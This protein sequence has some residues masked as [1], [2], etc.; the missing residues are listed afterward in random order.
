MLSFMRDQGGESLPAEQGAGASQREDA[1]PASRESQEFLTVAANSKNLRRSTILVA[2]LV[3]IGLAGLG[4]M[5]RQ[6][7]PQAALGEPALEE[8]NKIEVAISRL[9][10]V[11]SEMVSRMDEIVSKFY[12]F[13]DVFQVGVGELAKNP[14]E[15]GMFMGVIKDEGPT[16]QDA[17]AQA[18]L[19][20]RERLKERAGTLKLLSVMRSDDG[21]ACMI[22]DR[23]LHQGDSIEEL[24]ITQISGDSVLLTWHLDETVQAGAT[25]DLTIMLKLAK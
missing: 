14:F 7:Q 15:V 11:S 21:N 4:Y 22:N 1:A 13:S 8:E 23:I 5:I 12:E 25:E 6:S 10:G 20:R 16:P 19:V 3:A 2:V 17:A 18:A 24:T 9:T